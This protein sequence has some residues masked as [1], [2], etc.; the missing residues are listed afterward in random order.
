MKNIINKNKK[1]LKSFHIFF[2]LLIVTLIIPRLIVFISRQ[3]YMEGFAYYYFFARSI[4]IDHNFPLI[5][6]VVGDVG[7]FAQGAGWFYLLTIPFFIFNGNPFGMSVLIFCISIVTLLLGSIIGYT[8]IGKREGV[9]ISILLGT[10]PYLISWSNDIWP[11][12][13]VP[14]IA[15][16]YILGLLLFLKINKKRYFF[17]MPICLGAMAHFEIAS[18][19]LLFPSFISLTVF[20]FIK[21]KIIKKDILISA[22]FF[23]SFFIPHLIYDLKNNFYNLKGILDLILFKSSSDRSITLSATLAD[24]THLLI[25]DF[26]KVFPTPET[27]TLLLFILILLFGYLKLIGDKKIKN[28]QKIFTSYL[29]TSILLTF[30]SVC[31][32]PV[33]RASFWWLTYLTIFYIFFSGLITSY[34][35]STN[36]RLLKIILTVI[37]SIFAYSFFNNFLIILNNE[38][39]LRSVKYVI[40]KQSPIEFIYKDSQDK[41]FR[42]LFITGEKDVVD[43]KYM[44]WYVGKTDFPNSQAIKLLDLNYTLKGGVLF[45]YDESTQFSNLKNG[46]YYLIISKNS[47]ENGH[48]DKILKNVNLD[49]KDTNY[50]DPSGYFE[51]KKFNIDKN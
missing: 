3:E 2:I 4:I 21:N 6:P 47:V 50:I 9:L 43:Y 30:I 29:L 37:L 18:L 36:Y 44:L 42:T 5:G 40:S 27:G 32:L 33:E 19:G 41:P 28:W 31:I 23:G 26:I 49:L 51:V 39:Q 35:Y 14:F 24:R 20:L 10:S 8:I 17:I 46:L 45:S 13:V 34:I 15:V 1:T 22:I 48:I 7:G 16:L 38:K 25:T 12:Y 11:P